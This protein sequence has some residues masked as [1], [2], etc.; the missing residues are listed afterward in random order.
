MDLKTWL[1]ALAIGLIA[2][3][4]A[5]RT[6][7]RAHGLIPSLFIGVVGAGIGGWL[8]N[9]FALPLPGLFGASA[10]GAVV[11]LG[12]LSAMGRGR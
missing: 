4:I 3:L 6:A 11:T 7:T 8:A 12:L 1:G 10:A 9:I 2:G 5:A